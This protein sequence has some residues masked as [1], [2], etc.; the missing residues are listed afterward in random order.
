MVETL[1]ASIDSNLLA[2]GWD[3]LL[4]IKN[5]LLVFIGFSAVVFV[6]ELGHFAAAKWCNVRVDRFAVGFG[7]AIFSW[8]KGIG[9]RWGSTQAE[10]R[11]RIDE[12]LQRTTGRAL[13][14]AADAPE[15][16]VADADIPKAARELGLGET[17]Y[18]FNVLPLGGY[19]KMLGQEDFV[20]DK[21]GELMVRQDP[22]A[23]THKPIYQRMIIVSAGVV[24]NLVFAAFIFMGIF[25]VGMESPSAEVGLVSPGSPADKAGLRTGDVITC[26][27][28]R[29][30]SDQGDL[31]AAVVLSDPTEP[32]TVEFQRKDEATGELR[33]ESLKIHAEVLPGD[34]TRKL[35]VSPRFTNKVH[36][37]L[38]D[39]ALPKDQQIKVGDV[40]EQANGQPVTDAHILMSLM[41]N[42]WGAPLDL[43]VKRPPADGKGE[44]E[45]LSARMRGFLMLGSPGKDDENVL[46]FVPRQTFNNI[47][48]LGKAPSEQLRRGDVIVRWGGILAPR[49]S[50]IRESIKNS[51][52]KDIPV[53]VMR[54][55]KEESINVSIAAKGFRSSPSPLLTAGQWS[56]NAE[57]PVVAD[58]VESGIENTKTPAAALKGQMP[59][60]SLLTSINDQPV[61]TWPEVL[62]QFVALAGSDVKLSWTYE[63]TSEQSA[64]VHIPET[65]STALGL[66][67]ASVITSIDGKSR[68][69]V[70]V[71][72]RRDSYQVDHPLGQRAALKDLV[73][74]TVKVEYESLLKP[75]RETAEATITADMLNPWTRQFV[76]SP[77][78]ELILEPKF[79]TIQER[80]P[81]K[82]MGIGVW[83]TYYFIEQVYVT[84]KRMVYNRSV[85]M[86]QV[87]GPVGILKIGGE[88]AD[89]GWIP[90]FFFLAVISANL[91]VINFLPLPIVDGGLFLFLLI[92]LIK[93][94]PVS[95]KVQVATQV[96]GL[97]LIAC[98]FVY[99]TFLDVSKLW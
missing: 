98:I 12:H 45:V 89:H 47:P 71:N 63:G 95:L 35:G 7:K 21:S 20:V 55:G 77:P 25:M 41:L 99:V 59:R 43:T 58:I 96:I 54:G 44:P 87:S 27:N 88:L 16:E 79:K 78:V 37:I 39:P 69:E 30:I 42:N 83:K 14:S 24:M 97:A 57:T 9:F 18:C 28:G 31:K 48:E 82:A 36:F 49:M 19:V 62:R 91:A 11:G 2:W 86:D 32:L 72:G 6:H 23:F 46:G 66:P 33:S 22:R 34:D 52:G 60:G 50:E 81:F 93:G 80:N 92:E 51:P 38:P 75:G 3:T 1:V 13:S 73:G 84:M 94:K 68:V 15:A 90:L 85:S 4:Q 8:R 26:I 40:I 70:E 61:S 56:V 76:F 5:L 74:K 10:F 17:E 65:L 53:V 67:A 64:T 29:S